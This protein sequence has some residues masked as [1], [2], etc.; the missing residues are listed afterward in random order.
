MK[1]KSNKKDSKLNEARLKRRRIHELEDAR[2][3]FKTLDFKDTEELLAFLFCLISG[4]ISHL[5]QEISKLVAE[6][7]VL[8]D[9]DQFCLDA[10]MILLELSRDEVPQ[11]LVDQYLAIAE[12][13]A[14]VGA[15]PLACA[16]QGIKPLTPQQS[17]IYDLAC[18]VPESCGDD[19]P[20][21]AELV[22]KNSINNSR[23][24]RSEDEYCM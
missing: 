21:G 13:C 20:R 17:M 16:M 8:D 12:G 18:Q 14:A 19:G 9:S 4:D 11:N 6:E 5:L 22:I 24:A 2:R 23:H 10:L 1:R 15:S 3:W 7:G